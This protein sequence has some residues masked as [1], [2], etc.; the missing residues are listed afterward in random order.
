[1]KL[2]FTQFKIRLFWFLSVSVKTDHLPHFHV[3]FCVIVEI[4]EKCFFLNVSAAFLNLKTQQMIAV[5]FAVLWELFCNMGG[6]TVLA[7][8]VVY[9]TADCWTKPNEKKD[10]RNCIFFFY[11][12]TGKKKKPKKK[13]KTIALWVSCK[14]H[15]A[16]LSYYKRFHSPGAPDAQGGAHLRGQ[17]HEILWKGQAHKGSVLH[18]KL[19]SKAPPLPA[20]SPNAHTT[21]ETLQMSHSPTISSTIWEITTVP[22]V[23]FFF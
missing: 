19:V 23:F 13:K 21:T 1:M 17:S 2:H 15:I 4:V 10:Q 12:V 11:Y 18:R 6:F 20:T 5:V 22:K 16:D 3:N 14:L 9:V 8:C 7:G